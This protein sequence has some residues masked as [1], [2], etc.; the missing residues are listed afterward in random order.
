MID[1]SEGI[2]DGIDDPPVDVAYNRCGER[3]RSLQ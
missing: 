2:E 3:A 1:R